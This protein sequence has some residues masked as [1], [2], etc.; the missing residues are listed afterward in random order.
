MDIIQIL[1]QELKDI[2]IKKTQTPFNA[3]NLMYREVCRK[4]ELQ[5]R[6]FGGFK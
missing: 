6:I 1:R 5:S 3:L 2:E 4:E